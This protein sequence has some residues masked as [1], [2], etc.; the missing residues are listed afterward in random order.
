MI[1]PAPGKSQKRE[2]KIHGNVQGEEGRGDVP[3]HPSLQIP[4][5]LGRFAIEASALYDPRAG[6][7]WRSY[8]WLDVC[9]K[10]KGHVLPHSS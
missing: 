4:V 3:T 10:D 6:E 5:H 1:R 2:G 8:M 9:E 7:F